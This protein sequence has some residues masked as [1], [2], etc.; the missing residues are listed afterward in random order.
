MRLFWLFAIQFWCVQISL[1][2]DTLSLPEVTITGSNSPAYSFGRNIITSDSTLVKFGDQSLGVILESIGV[3]YLKS[4]GAGSSAIF[5]NQGT[6]PQHN[7]IIWNGLA[8]NNMLLGLSDIS[9]LN[10]DENTTLKIIQGTS[11][12]YWGSGA[13]GSTLLMETQ[14]KESN[15][16][17]LSFNYNSLVNQ[18]YNIKIQRKFSKWVLLGNIGLSAGKNRFDVRNYTSPTSEIR[19]YQSPYLS[20][21]SEISFIRNFNNKHS[22]EAHILFAD[23]SREL[24]SSLT[25]TEK[26]SQ[27][28]DKIFRSVVQ[29]KKIYKNFRIS[30]LAGYTFDQIQ[31]KDGSVN[32]TG[33]IHSLSFKI[34]GQS[35]FKRGSLYITGQSRFESA[36]N[37]SFKSS[38]RRNLTSILSG[39]SYNLYKNVFANFETRFEVVDASKSIFVASGALEA[40]FSNTILKAYISGS[41]NNPSLNDLYWVPGGNVALKPERGINGGL[42]LSH[43]Q[44]LGA[45]QTLTSIEGFFHDINDWIQWIPGN[46]Y[47]SPVNYKKVLSTGF[48]FDQRWLYVLRE[49][50]YLFDAGLGYTSSLNKTENNNETQNKQLAYMPIL[51]GN[52]SLSYLWRKFTLRAELVGIGKRFT[53]FDESAE[54]PAYQLVNLMVGSTVLVFRTEFKPFIQINNILNQ[55]YESVVFR[56]REPRNIF[57]GFKINFL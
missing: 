15:K 56:P 7:Q 3:G 23:N 5:S 48:R 24:S 38:V 8:T 12:G 41:Y 45:I 52:V 25:E 17:I 22:I 13:I 51:K 29:W 43:R 18:Q 49:H 21:R 19:K 36:N 2:A 53:V 4:Y 26:F 14:L 39:L 30:S 50:K 42:T 57:I 37:S 11:S 33:Q 6:A 28:K 44:N 10:I 32:D 27:Q 16:L 40:S 34:E 20:K 55:Y 9:L 35:F 1:C 54:L 47:W 46:T 31:F